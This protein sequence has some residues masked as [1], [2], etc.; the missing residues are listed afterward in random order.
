MAGMREARESRSTRELACV[1]KRYHA[2]RGAAAKQRGCK[3]FKALPLSGIAYHP[4][5]LAGGPTKRPPSSDD[6]TIGT[7]S[8]VTRVVDRLRAKHRFAGA[9]HLSLWLTEFGVQTDPPDYLFGAPMVLVPPPLTAFRS[10]LFNPISCVPPL[11]VRM[12]LA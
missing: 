3:G 6:A 10:A 9:R 4:Y 7:L 1:D 8:R 2:F 11:G 12:P 5:A